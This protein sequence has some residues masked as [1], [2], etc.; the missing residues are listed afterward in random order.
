MKL[1][2]ICT[3]S[4]FC[5]RYNAF[6]ERTIWLIRPYKLTYKG[7]ERILRKEGWITDPSAS[8]V[9]LETAIFF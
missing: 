3:V 4:C 6:A 2:N 7:A 8:V 5:S 9:R 1:A